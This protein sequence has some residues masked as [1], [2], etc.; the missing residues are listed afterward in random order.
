MNSVAESM[1]ERQF[2][3]PSRIQFR[4]GDIEPFCDIAFA[5]EENVVF[6]LLE[7]AYRDVNPMD[8]CQGENI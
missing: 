5:D 8:S 2:V 7:P 4:V 1:P 6:T 3:I